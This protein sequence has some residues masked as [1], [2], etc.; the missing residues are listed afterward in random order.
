MS[1][2]RILC[3]VATLTAVTACKT[4]T[5]AIQTSSSTTTV[6]QA[7]PLGSRLPPL[8]PG[9]SYLMTSSPN[10]TGYS[11]AVVADVTFSP[12]LAD[13]IGIALRTGSGQIV[14]QVAMGDNTLF[15]ERTP[16]EPFGSLNSDRSYLRVADTGDNRQDFRMIAPSTPRNRAACPA[17]GTSFR[18]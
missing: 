4:N 17:A 6:G 9:C 13:T 18:D 2:A 15:K 5:P 8:N 7:N 12:R 16:L 1:S 3:V 14:D 10:A 11:G